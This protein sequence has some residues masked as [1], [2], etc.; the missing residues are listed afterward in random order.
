[1]LVL[2]LLGCAGSID[3]YTRLDDGQRLYIDS[4]DTQAPRHWLLADAVLQEVVLVI[5]QERS[6]RL[7]L[8]EVL[9]PRTLFEAVIGGAADDIAACGDGRCVYDALDAAAAGN[10]GLP[11]GPEWRECSGVVIGIHHPY[12]SLAETYRGSCIDDTW[13]SRPATLTIRE[14]AGPCGGLTV[15][16]GADASCE[17][18][19]DGVYTCDGASPDRL[20]AYAGDLPDEL[21]TDVRR[22][23]P[24]IE[25]YSAECWTESWGARFCED[26]EWC[27]LAAEDRD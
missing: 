17:Y 5:A 19:R 20:R 25:R 1:M 18:D 23:G 8:V 21:F 15:A 24:V 26:P 27:L 22:T 7:A 9:D 12:I 10:R 13:A 3:G 11:E 16:D 4:F 2:A 14:V 6:E